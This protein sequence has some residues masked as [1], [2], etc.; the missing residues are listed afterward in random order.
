MHIIQKTALTATAAAVVLG[1]A[2]VSFAQ[3]VTTSASSTTNATTTTATTTAVVTS[4]PVVSTPTT[5]RFSGVISSL[6]QGGFTL[7]NTAGRAI[8]IVPAAG[9]LVFVNEEP[10]AV[11]SLANGMQGNVYGTWAGST[12]TINASFINADSASVSGVI[13]GVSGTNVTV[14]SGTHTITVV[15]AGTVLVDH[16]VGSTASLV[17]GMTIT[18]YGTWTDQSHSTINA[19]FV[20]ANHAGVSGKVGQVNGNQI[21][22]VNG[23]GK[24]ISVQ[25]GSATILKSGVPSSLA[26]ILDGVSVSV[27]GLWTDATESALTAV[28]VFVSGTGTDTSSPNWCYTFYNNLRVGSQGT[29]VSNLQTALTQSGFG[30]PVTGNYDQTTA[31]A[32]S[33]F[34]EKYASD[35]LTPNGLSYGTGFVGAATRGKLNALY[36]CSDPINA[37]GAGGDNRS[38]NPWDTW[39]W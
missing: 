1:F 14:T 16:L 36:A 8:T 39:Q 38:G 37:Q 21:T 12:T 17:S 23:S 19:A 9:A 4:A 7:T 26:A 5:A 11:A 29:E 18:A 34:Q 3:V 10:S 15:P 33:G 20:N 30:V 28:D 31:S 35:I 13:T 27:Y 32:V 24:Q 25:A 6:G 22:V 2:S